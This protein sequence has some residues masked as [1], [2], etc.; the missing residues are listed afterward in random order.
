[1]EQLVADSWRLGLGEPVAVSAA[2][3]EGLADLY[4]ALQPVVDSWHRRINAETL[5]LC[6]PWDE[7]GKAHSAAAT[8]GP[9]IWA[10]GGLPANTTEPHGCQG[11]SSSRTSDGQDGVEGVLREAP[12]RAPGSSCRPAASSSPPPADVC[13]P[14]TATAHYK[15]PQQEATAAVTSETAA[16]Q[17][18][19]LAIVG[20]PNVVRW[21]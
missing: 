14:S 21:F 3:G 17:A 8:A 19:R 2:S 10:D 4:I 1:M 16:G 11:A 6:A 7:R 18:L 9:G 5:A 13:W 15:G 20:L 12:G